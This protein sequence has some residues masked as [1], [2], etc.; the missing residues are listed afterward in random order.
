MMPHGADGVPA[1]RHRADHLALFVVLLCGGYLAAL[2]WIDRGNGTFAR[3]GAIWPLL[4]LAVLPV[5]VS[6]LFR[7]WRWRWLLQRQGHAVPFGLGW[8]AYLAG[9]ALT[10]TPGKAGEL[11]RIRYFARMGVPAGRTL[12]VFVFERASDL[13]VILALSL[14]A[15]PVFPTLGTLAA[16]VL[17]F[18]ALLFGAAAWPALLAWLEG[19]GRRLPGRWLRRTAQFAVFAATELRACLGTAQ[20]VR[21]LI[22]GAGA[23]GLTSAVFVGLCS[24]LG[25][26]LDPLVAFGIY[27]LAMLIGA[28]S[29]VPGGVG[30]TELAIVLMLDRLGV[31]TADA[32]AVAVAARLVTLWYAVAVGALAMGATE[33]LQR[34]Q[35]A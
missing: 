27:P 17:G 9:F 26:D 13:L 35:A 18:V 12:A 7:F 21:S 20:M 22:A 34:R 5:S 33:F 24:G 3:L 4:A 25:L 11:L 19:V 31:A 30:T 6:Y 8:A 28:L 16:V 32:I 2:W 15:A 23:W 10:A 29:F 1:P 14:L